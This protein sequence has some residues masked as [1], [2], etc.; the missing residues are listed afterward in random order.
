MGIM[1]DG[2]P[3][4]PAPAKVMLTPSMTPEESKAEQE[5]A[6][7]IALEKLHRDVNAVM[8]TRE[9]RN[10]FRRLLSPEHTKHYF[11]GMSDNNHTT[12]YNM[13]KRSIGVGIVSMLIDARESNYIKLLQTEKV[14]D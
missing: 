7:R 10:V 3:K 1:M 11:T 5:K 9:G 6:T 14:D 4:V 13:G 8:D 2:L 12:I